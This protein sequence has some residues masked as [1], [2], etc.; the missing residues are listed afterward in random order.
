[1][2]ST[3]AATTSS[4]GDHDGRVERVVVLEPGQLDDL[5][6]QPGQAVGLRQ[7]PAGETAYGDR[8]VGRVAHGLGEQLD[9][10]DRRL[11]LV[12]DVGHE[13]AAHRLDP[14]LAGAVLDQRQHQRRATAA[15]PGP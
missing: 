13:V 11:E 2:A 6:H 3:A 15:R 9:R 10:A 5:L 4:T 14:A 7:H 12:G 8:V 1:M